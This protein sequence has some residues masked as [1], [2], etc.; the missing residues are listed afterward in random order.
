[1]YASFVLLAF[2]LSS[3]LSSIKMY[4]FLFDIINSIRKKEDSEYDFLL[5]MLV[6]EGHFFFM[7]FLSEPNNSKSVTI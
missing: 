2:L 4:L 3:I 6:S 5:I 7:N 1:M